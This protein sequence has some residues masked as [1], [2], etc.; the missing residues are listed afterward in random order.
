MKE[1][2]LKISGMSCNMCVKSIKNLLS[3]LDGIIDV[4]IDLE[5]GIGIIKYDENII[6]ENDILNSE[7]FELYPAEKI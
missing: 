1:L 5:G 2:K 4:G 3:E 6:T 7:A